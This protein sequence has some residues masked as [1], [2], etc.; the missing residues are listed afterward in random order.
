MNIILLHYAAPPIIGGVESVIG[1]HARLMSKNGHRVSIIAGRG[2]KTDQNI[3]FTKL[4]LIDSRHE[5]IL[6]LKKELDNGQIPKGFGE[7][8]EQIKSQLLEVLKG[9][10]WLIAHNVCSLNKN[11]A[12][13]AALKEIS[14]SRVRPRFILWHH[15][16]A[17]TTPRYRNELHEGYPWDLL[18]HDWQRTIHCFS[19]SA[20]E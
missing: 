8:V 3:L 13:T 7:V 4:P 17:W 15:D 5:E 11:L 16:L 14:E 18:S 6:A 19:A 9:A 12:L 1:Q 10:D 2:E 20:T